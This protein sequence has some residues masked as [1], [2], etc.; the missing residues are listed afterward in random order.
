MQ[1]C[2]SGRGG[3]AGLLRSLLKLQKR[4]RCHV[5][6]RCSR[7]RVPCF[8]LCFFLRQV[9]CGCGAPGPGTF[10]PRVGAC[11]HSLPTFIHSMSMKISLLLFVVL[12]LGGASGDDSVGRLGH[13][14]HKKPEGDSNHPTRLS[15]NARA[16]KPAPP[17]PARPPPSS[18]P[19]PAEA[20]PAAAAAKAADPAPSKYSMYDFSDDYAEDLSWLHSAR[21]CNPSQLPATLLKRAFKL[22]FWSFRRWLQLL[23]VLQRGARGGR[24]EA[25][26][27]FRA[28]KKPGERKAK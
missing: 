3:P 8:K 20:V 4:Q 11:P 7:L 9:S 6:C 19:P 28:R 23:H 18:P 27:D 21:R 15:A 13:N 16:A 10:T 17:K 2:T 24:R 5:S 26:R 14:Y 12:V 1:C 25:S 22:I